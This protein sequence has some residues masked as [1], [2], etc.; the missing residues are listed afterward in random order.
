MHIPNPSVKHMLLFWTPGKSFFKV[1]MV[2]NALKKH[3]KEKNNT[4]SRLRLGQN[5]ILFL[6]YS[7]ID[8][9][10]ASSHSS[11]SGAELLG[12]KEVLSARCQL[13]FFAFF[14]LFFLLPWQ[15]IPPPSNNVSHRQQLGGFWAQITSGHLKNIWHFSKHNTFLLSKDTT[16]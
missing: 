9:E 15:Q 10:M 16:F 8:L 13:L 5:V 14:L 3:A 6:A 2:W 1:K 4:S 11:L 12:A 7:S